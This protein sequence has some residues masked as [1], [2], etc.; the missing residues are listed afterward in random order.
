VPV[1]N[2]CQ[3][4]DFTCAQGQEGYGTDTDVAGS[5]VIAGAFEKV[6]PATLGAAEKHR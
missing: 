1:A 3:W 4:L 2:T 6:V 5:Q